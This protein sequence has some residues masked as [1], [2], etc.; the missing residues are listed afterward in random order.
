M[1]YIVCPK[2]G[3]ARKPTDTGNAGICPACGIVFAKW[4]S[5]VLGAERLREEDDENAGMEASRL[6]WL[7]DYL[8]YVE[9]RTDSMV[10]WGRVAVYIVLFLWGWHFILLNYRDFAFMESFMHAINL[11]FHEAGHV[12]FSPFGRFIHILGGTL[13]QLLMPIIVG[14]VFVIGNR[15]NFG[16]SIGL[17]W[18][19]QSFMDCAPYVADAR[20]GILP[21]TGGG[22]GEEQPWRHDWFNIL[23]DLHLLQHDLQIGFGFHVVGSI[24]MLLAFA[25]GG[26]ILLR[27]YRNLER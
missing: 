2:C 5:R 20:A 6:Q 12:V 18:L 25:W 26:I 8:G 11:P 22:N 27:Q 23:G 24:L 14:A 7:V 17:W 13:G 9:P 10:F 16:G 21:L 3:Y 1:A 19:G 4:T 15:N